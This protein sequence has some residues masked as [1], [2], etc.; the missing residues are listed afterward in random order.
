MCLVREICFNAS[1]VYVLGHQG[2]VLGPLRRVV[3][4]SSEPGSSSSSADEPQ[5]L[6]QGEASSS[7]AI[8]QPPKPAHRRSS[9]SIIRS[10]HQPLVIATTQLDEDIREK[11]KSKLDPEQALQALLWLETLCEEEFEEDD[12]HQALKSGERL[13]KAMNR[14]R[15][16]SIRKINPKGVAFKELENITQYLRCCR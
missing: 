10:S 2:P 6:D 13:C 5:L 7:S 4:P 15:P 11:L 12:L 9:T 16:G 14:I 8:P 3:S 1:L